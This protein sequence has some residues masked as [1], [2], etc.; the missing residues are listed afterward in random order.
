MK[1]KMQKDTFILILNVLH[2]FESQEI[3][4]RYKALLKQAKIRMISKDY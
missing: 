1:I 4:H 2:N 3:R